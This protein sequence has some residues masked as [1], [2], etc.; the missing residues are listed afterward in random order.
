MNGRE[1]G[2]P[3]GFGKAGAYAS[4]RDGSVAVTLVPG[5][6]GKALA[7]K[8]L[9]LSDG[10]YTVIAAPSGKGVVLRSYR[11]GS[12]QDGKARRLH[13]L[14]SSCRPAATRSR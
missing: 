14:P 10:R 12:P 6:G 4:A 1:L 11:D 9:G 2:S 7:S 5:G 13:A 3:V 8:E